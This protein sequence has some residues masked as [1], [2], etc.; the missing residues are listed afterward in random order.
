MSTVSRSTRIA[1]PAEEVWVM[2]SDLPSMGDRSPEN[3]GGRWTGGAT[4]PAVGATF[5][6]SNQRGWRRWSTVVEVVR[7]V[8]G[9][10]FAFSVKVF[11]MRV[12]DWAYDVTPEGTDSCSVTETWTDRRGPLLLRVGPLLT[13]VAD[14]EAF[15]ASSIETTLA[16]LKTR[17]EAA[18]R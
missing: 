18:D 17:A 12:A 13:G 3:V 10:E 8:P 9:S 6:G 15:T 1:A 4:G 16:S 5:K 7:S 14:R 2:L 11:G